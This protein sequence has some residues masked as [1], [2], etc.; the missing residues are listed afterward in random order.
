M[1]TIWAKLIAATQQHATVWTDPLGRLVV[2]R[3]VVIRK[4]QRAGYRRILAFKRWALRIG[5]AG[6]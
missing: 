5:R 2:R 6:A 1:T 3:V 4:G